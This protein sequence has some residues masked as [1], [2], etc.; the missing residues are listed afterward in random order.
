MDWLYRACV[1]VGVTA[2]VLISAVIPWAGV[3]ALRAEQ[4]SLVAGADGGVADDSRDI[5]R[6][7]GGIP[8]QRSH[9]PGV[10]RQHAAAGATTHR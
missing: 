2:L 5:H 7:R 4:C 3:H 8:L 9:E 1:V 6:R 10:L